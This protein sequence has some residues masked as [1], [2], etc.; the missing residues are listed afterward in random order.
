V[1]ITICAL[2]VVTL[3]GCASVHPEDLQSWVGAPVD[4][5][6]KHPIFLTMQVV[7]TR[8]ADGTEI[9]DYVN[10][11]N[12][13]SCSGGGNVNVFAGYVDTATYSRFSACMQSFRACHNIFYIKDGRVTQY[14]PIG[15]GGGRCYTSEELRPGF[16]GAVNVR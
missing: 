12:F 11:H 10:G 15:T 5:L 6:D 13:A 9:R 1:R 7:R 2:L 3:A 8:T 16:V 4:Q 14:S